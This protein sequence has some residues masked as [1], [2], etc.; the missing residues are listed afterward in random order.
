M[1]VPQDVFGN[2]SGKT[3]Q[4]SSGCSCHGGGANQVTP[5]LSGLPS[6]GYEPTTD[7]VLTIGGSGTPSG[8]KGGFNL[9]ANL[10]SFS[11]PGTNAKLMNGEV[12]HSNYNSRTWTVNWTAPSNGSGNTTFSLAVNFVNGNGNTGGDGWGTNS[13]TLSQ[14]EPDTDGDGW[15]DSDESA[16]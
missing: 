16:C 1:A 2:A 6:G 13:W 9:D 8:S 4:S 5:S 11:N 12:T 10:G 15:S 7:Y 14:A 3:G